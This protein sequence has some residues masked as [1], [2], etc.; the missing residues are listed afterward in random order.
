MDQ[1][2]IGIPIGETR[3]MTA[4]EIEGLLCDTGSPVRDQAR[5]LLSKFDAACGRYLGK[6]AK[7]SEIVE[8][9][10]IISG[11]QRWDIARPE[12]D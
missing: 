7:R 8:K 1:A 10:P 5:A 12:S 3:R 2:C 6:L 11:I 4:S 9:G